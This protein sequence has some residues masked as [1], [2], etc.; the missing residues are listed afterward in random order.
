VSFIL[1]FFLLSIVVLF[2]LTAFN[3]VPFFNY[4]AVTLVIALLSF[5]FYG[6]VFIRPVELYSDS[7]LFYITIFF[8][9]FNIGYGMWFEPGEL[10]MSGIYENT[11]NF[12]GSMCVFYSAAFYQVYG[13][14]SR[15]KMLLLILLFLFIAIMSQSKSIG[16]TVFGS[17]LF[18]LWYASKPKKYLVLVL[19]SGLLTLFFLN[20]QE[21]A[22]YGS[23]N[24]LRFER[25]LSSLN[26]VT[27]FGIGPE[28]FSSMARF[29][30]ANTAVI[31]SFVISLFLFSPLYF[32]LLI[33]FILYKS[34]VLSRYS[35]YTM[36][37]LF[38]LTPMF[39][40]SIL[41]PLTVFNGLLLLWYINNVKKI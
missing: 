4:F 37:V 27:F 31:E 23:S 2:K 32:L 29:G 15:F 11:L 3:N 10:R 34:I 8:A 26:Y 20:F 33:V 40:G 13:G 35:F 21:V 1:L 28:A 9:L 36:K 14:K 24:L 30:I 6:S 19:L 17:M 25:Y 16:I 22:P 12:T 41:T 38:I 39:T 5:A 7:T 18:M